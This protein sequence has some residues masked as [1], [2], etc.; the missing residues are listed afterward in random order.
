[1]WKELPSSGTSTT[2]VKKQRVM[3]TRSAETQI[4]VSG[5]VAGAQYQFGVAGIN[6]QGEGPLSDLTVPQTVGFTMATLTVISP[7]TET[8]TSLAPPINSSPN[9]MARTVEVRLSLPAVEAIDKVTL[10]EDFVSQATAL[11]DL[12]MLKGVCDHPVLRFR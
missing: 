8:P 3:Y 12:V 2:L 11:G 6:G 7:M 5:L 9:W 4:W 10:H 1:M